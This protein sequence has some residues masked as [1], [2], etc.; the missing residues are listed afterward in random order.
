MANQIRMSNPNLV[1]ELA[2][3]LNQSGSG[4]QPPPGT[5]PP[6]GQPPPGK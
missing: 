1:E 6:G 4:P 5:Q 2:T 3:R